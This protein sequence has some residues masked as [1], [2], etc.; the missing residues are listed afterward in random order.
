MKTRFAKLFADTLTGSR[1]ARRTL[2]LFMVCALVPIVV[3]SIQNGRRVDTLFHEHVSE[4]LKRSSK[5]IGLMLFDR[6]QY[7]DR[8]VTDLEARLKQAR[9][10]GSAGFRWPRL[11]SLL[12]E[13]LLIGAGEENVRA[14]LGEDT[15]AWTLAS[16]NMPGNDTVVVTAGAFPDTRIWLLRR[17]DEAGGGPLLAARV[18]T[19]YVWQELDEYDYTRVFSIVTADGRLLF[20]TSDEPPNTLSRGPVPLQASWGMFLGNMRL[21]EN[22]Q[23]V[24]RVLDPAGVTDDQAHFRRYTFTTSLLALLMAALIGAYSI[25]KSTEPLEALRRGIDH[26]RQNDF[27]H[28]VAIHS[29]DE[30]ELLGNAFNTMTGK[31]DQHINAIRALSA[32]DQLLFGPLKIEDIVRVVLKEG[33]QIL[34][35]DNL[36]LFLKDDDGDDYYRYASADN[37]VEAVALPPTILAKLDCPDRLLQWAD[38]GLD[39]ALAPG[40]DE[41]RQVYCTHLKAGGELKAV[42]VAEIDARHDDDVVNIAALFADHVGFALSNANWE[43][44]LYKQAHY[45]SLTG[46]PNRYSF[47]AQLAVSVNQAARSN[48]HFAVLFIDIDDF[49]LINEAMGLEAGDDFLAA[50]AARLK[51]TLHQDGFLARLGGDEFALIYACDD[52]SR[53]LMNN[54]IGELVENLRR[55]ASEEMV[56]EGRELQIAVSI[57]IAV[58]PFD[59]EKVDE[60]MKFADEAKRRAK[61]AGKNRVHYFSDIDNYSNVSRLDFMSELQRALD[62]DELVLYYQPKVRASDGRI[63]GCEALVR[64]NH[65]VRGLLSPFFF[66]PQ[67]EEYGMIGDIGRW[68]LRS[69]AAQ[70]AAWLKAGID[71]G[72]VAVNVS[73]LELLNGGF[74]EE[75]IAMLAETAC[76]GHALEVE[77][78]ET[79]YVEDMENF[80]QHM[81]NLSREGLAFSVDDYGTGY[82]SLSMLLNLPVSQIKIDKSFIDEV[83]QSEKSLAIIETTI[84]LA[85]KVGYK[86]VA[87]GVESAGQFALL[88]SL[89]CDTIQGYYFSKPV[90][91]DELVVMSQPHYFLNLLQ[92]DKP[93]P[94]QGGRK[95][96][97][98]RVVDT[99]RGQPG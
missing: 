87:E 75:V 13:A 51:K 36:Y 41:D 67:A 24:T 49:K 11:P 54:R 84:M 83:E 88:Q 91:A 53:S 72:R 61:E 43:A 76:P 20:T 40:R 98:L 23:V 86:V 62:R 18:D 79:A 37:G 29:N 12:V 90:P 92:G 30:Y 57:G 35:A 80:R 94:E 9:A 28:R 69:A 33:M 89:G 38:T 2:L 17:L 31:L 22:W 95:Q 64:W 39:R 10:A 55:G 15:E 99:G 3:L 19:D 7:L 63:D 1:I 32:I 73:V 71:V 50:F 21:P 8:Q 74:C 52:L 93:A 58:Y 45:D 25:R 14:L 96:P 65:P 44:R 5:G 70:Q 4:D 66:I 34:Q 47:N 68:V 60:L 82:S 59:S 16:L 85:K 26:I 27:S 81:D 42:L 77:I 97:V 6:F 78:T 56:L 48:Q 46:L